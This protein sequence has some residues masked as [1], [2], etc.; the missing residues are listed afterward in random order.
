MSSVFP[1]WCFLVKVGEHNCP[2][3]GRADYITI[4]MPG[5]SGNYSSAILNPLLQFAAQWARK[6]SSLPLQLPTLLYAALRRSS[7]SAVTTLCRAG[8][9]WANRV[10]A[11]STTNPVTSALQTGKKS[12][13]HPLPLQGGLLLL[14]LPLHFNLGCCYRKISKTFP[15]GRQKWTD[16]WNC[17]SFLPPQSGCCPA[18]HTF[19]PLS[20]I[21]DA[22][23]FSPRFSSDF[24]GDPMTALLSKNK[25]LSHLYSLSSYWLCIK[26]GEED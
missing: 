17:L 12:C 14:F 13:S 4:G 26:V 19:F 22:F 10:L 8:H 24:S 18:V 7:R 5:L 23:R 3:K 16:N 15:D 9:W 20:S 11:S 2:G 25:Y 1:S 6:D 21:S